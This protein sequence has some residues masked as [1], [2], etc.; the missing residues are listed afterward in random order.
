MSAQVLVIGSINVDLTVRTSRIPQPGE[1]LTG[2]GPHTYSGG[3]GANQ[4]VAAARLGAS[5]GFLGAV[6]DDAYADLALAGL[7]AA[8]VDLRDLAV[9]PGPC[10]MALITVDDAGENT[11]II[12][13]GA[14]AAV[15]AD[16][17]DAVADRIAAAD[18]VV[19]Q[20]E[21]PTDALV[22]ASELAR[23]RLIW[24]LAPA[25]EVPREAL[26]RADP[27]VVNEHEARLVLAAL[28]APA[29]VSAEAAA[30][31]LREVGFAS[32]V[33]TLGAEGALVAEGTITKGT[34]TEGTITK[35]TVAE[36]TITKGTV[37]EGTGAGDPVVRVPSPRID[38]VDTTGA[39]DAFVGAL[40]AGLTRGESLVEAARFAARVGAYACLRPGAQESYPGVDDPLP[41]V[42][43]D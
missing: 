5:V 26:L 27:L 18:F 36:G 38:A 11:I 23:G 37:T 20:A 13:P 7:R 17:L 19:L 6:G 40:V 39:G 41:R 34:V 24:N 8:G 33:I 4:A 43:D 14:N 1:T 3:K 28:G 30:T 2:S 10:G 21:I 25:R 42:S 32:V 29:P 9:V 16:R 15:T 12:T 31:T 35:G 22:R